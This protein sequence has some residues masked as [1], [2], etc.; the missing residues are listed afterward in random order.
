MKI[1][2]KYLYLEEECSFEWGTL[3]LLDEGSSR[4]I[5]GAAHLQI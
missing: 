5:F 4:P 2:I 1:S 3:V